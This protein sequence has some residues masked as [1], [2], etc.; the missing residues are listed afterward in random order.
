MTD[1]SNP[2]RWSPRRLCAVILAASLAIAGVSGWLV[3]TA[4]EPET[5]G[6]GSSG[7]ALVGGPFDLIDHDGHA[8]TDA[9]FRGR[10]L[11][12]YFGY[13]FCP[14]I[15]PLELDAISRAL[16]LLGPDARNVQPLF[17]TV[18]PGRDTVEVMAQYIARFHPAFR[19]LTGSDDRIRD[20][21]GAYLVH[22]MKADHDAD[23]D[24]LN[25]SS[26]IYLMDGEG[27]YLTHFSA[28]A[29]PEE[30]AREIRARVR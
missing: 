20:V 1:N 2:G 22:Y 19:A 29:A 26:Y 23:H 15:C 12:V 24:L 27:K 3:S 13:T 4:L 5:R 18:D 17:I 8:V 6:A 14:D 21:A 11:L 30:M 25:H 10:F 9:D 16:D 7:E 28:G